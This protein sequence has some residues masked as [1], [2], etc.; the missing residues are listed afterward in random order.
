[1]DDTC[2]ITHDASGPGDDVFDQDTGTLTPPAPDTVELYDGRCLIR[3]ESVGKV[4]LEG[5]AYVGDRD[6][7][8]RLPAS[9]PEVPR[10]ATLTVTSSRR[11]PQLVGKVFRVLEV[12]IGTFLIARRVTLE[13]RD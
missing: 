6:Y 3:R 10:G 12:S 1:M 2:V 4:I 9:T 7:V 5:G 13:L 8:A 11:D